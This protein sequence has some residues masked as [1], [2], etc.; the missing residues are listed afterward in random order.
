MMDSTDHDIAMSLMDPQ[1]FRAFG[2]DKGLVQ[3]LDRV[4]TPA[5][6]RCQT[7]MRQLRERTAG[8]QVEPDLSESEVVWITALLKHT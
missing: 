7:L 1:W 5:G 3:L 4:R 6:Q 2:A 8:L